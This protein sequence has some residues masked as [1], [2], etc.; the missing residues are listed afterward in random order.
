MHLLCS[1]L[2]LEKHVWICA[3]MAVGVKHQCTVG[4]VATTHEAEIRAVINELSAAAAKVTHPRLSLHGLCLSLSPSY[5]YPHISQKTQMSFSGGVEDRLIAYAKSVAH[6]PTALKEFE[7]LAEEGGRGMEEDG[8][9]LF[10]ACPL[11]SLSLTK[12]CSTV[13]DVVEERLVHG[14]QLPVHRPPA[15]ARSLSPPLRTHP[16]CS[17][18]PVPTG[19]GV[20]GGSAKQISLLCPRTGSNEYRMDRSDG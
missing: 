17:R 3:F 15:A 4:E 8:R 6:F 12:L 13:I 16:A 19:A 18:E 20:V 1:L 9:P 7:V 10:R 11:L 5:A 2:Q 14:H